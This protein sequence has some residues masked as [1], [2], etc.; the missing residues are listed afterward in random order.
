MAALS[1]PAFSATQPAESS[2]SAGVSNYKEADI[3]RHDVV[4]GDNRRYDIEISQ[5]RLVTP[6]GTRWSVD[7]G[8]SR[9]T[10]SGASPWATVPGLD[11]E[12]DLIMSGATIE[13]ART[14]VNLSAVCHEQSGGLFDM[15]S[16]VLRRVWHLKRTVL[17]TQDE[18]NGFLGLV[19]WDKVNCSEETVYLPIAG[20]ELDFGG[21]VK[22]YAADV[23]ANVARQ[24]GIRHGLINLG[25]DICVVGPQPGGDPWPIGIVHPVNTDSA[26]ATVSLT[27]GALT[28]SGS[29][30]RYV[31]IEGARYSHLIDPSTGWPVEG[32]L[33]VSVAAP[34]AVV[35]GSVA[36]IALLKPPEDGL[37]WLA[38]CD[39]SFLAVDSRLNCYGHLQDNQRAGSITSN[40]NRGHSPDPNPGSAHG[41]TEPE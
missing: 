29:Y 20:M 23:A 37:D 6:I 22:E 34:Q 15:T 9:E 13:D 21:V 35:A 18:L 25:G 36:S 17:P 27:D 12:A 30:E 11:G 14:E 31:E 24:A 19:G 32:L 26:L 1:L 28:T 3:P 33:S 8:V 7:L 39:L 16:G 40:G 2:V 4:G 41:C 5:F 10:M 38:R